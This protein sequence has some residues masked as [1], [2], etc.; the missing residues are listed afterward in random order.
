VNI[1]VKY[2]SM[3]HLSTCYMHAEWRRMS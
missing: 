3:L 2:Q 1:V